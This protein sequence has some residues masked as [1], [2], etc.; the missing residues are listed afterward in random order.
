MNRSISSI[1]R[2]PPRAPNIVQFSAAA[3]Q[4]NFSIRGKGQPW[5][6]A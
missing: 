5:S 1:G 3:A 6:K 2:I 4:L